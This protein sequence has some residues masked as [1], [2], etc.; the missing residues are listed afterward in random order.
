MIR[1]TPARCSPG[2]RC[3]DLPDLADESREV[4]L[5]PPDRTFDDDAAVDSTPAGGRRAAPSR[6]RPHRQR[7]RRPGPRRRRPVRRRPAR[8]RRDAVLRRRLSARLAGDGRGGSSTSARRR[9]ARPR[10]RSAIGRSPNGRSTEI[11]TIAELGRSVATGG[12][13]V[14]EAI[15]RSPT[16]RRRRESP[17]NGLRPRLEANSTRAAS[18]DPD[19]PAA[20]GAPARIAVERRFEGV[21][22]SPR[23]PTR[24][25]R[26]AAGRSRAG[27]TGVAA[28][29]SACSPSPSRAA[30]RRAG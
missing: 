1:E 3:G 16:S 25:G 12:L 21:R 26:A 2:A 28:P 10:R 8:E 13:S 18:A 22:A 5:D 6:P 23:W 4:V 17:S 29:R 14:N 7:H 9:R 19:Y 30:P 11:R 27:P 15:H 24:P 20:P